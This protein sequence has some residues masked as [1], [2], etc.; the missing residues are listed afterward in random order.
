MGKCCFLI[1]DG[2]QSKVPCRYLIRLPSGKTLCRIYK[3]RLG[4]DIGHGNRC[5]M[6]KDSKIN[7]PGC[8]MNIL[9]PEN[10]GRK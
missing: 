4:K 3:T 9:T 8:T 5:I 10:D 1:I 6:R 7:Y 2:K